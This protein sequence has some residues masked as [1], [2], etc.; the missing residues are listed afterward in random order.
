MKTITIERV[1]NGWIVRPFT[2]GATWACSDAPE[3]A[4]YTEIADLQQDLPKLM[5]VPPVVA[6]C[7]PKPETFEELCARSYQAT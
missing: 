2:P 6:P 1:S 4:V 7:V 3:I 5:D